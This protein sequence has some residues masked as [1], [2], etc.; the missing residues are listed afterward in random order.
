[1]KEFLRYEKDFP[2]M[3]KEAMFLGTVMHS[4]DHANMDVLAEVRNFKGSKKFLGNR[5][6]AT[7]VFCCFSDLPHF[8]TFEC[9]FSHAPHPLFRNVFTFASRI[10]KRLADSLQ[11]CINM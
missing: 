6:L 7:A 2:G 11:C 3:D 4:I 8:M 5:E 9:R 1:M 10:D